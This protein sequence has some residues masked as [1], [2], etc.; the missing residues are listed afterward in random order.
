MTSELDARF[1]PPVVGAAT[2]VRFPVISRT[3]LPNGLR[4]WSLPWAP[5]PVAA[6][7]FILNHGAADDPADRPGLASLTADLVDEGAGTR[8]TVGLAAAF[9]SLGTHLEVEAGS[10]STALAFTVLTRFFE[11]ALDLVV[12]VLLRPRLAEVDLTRIRAQR[13]NRLRQ[14]KTSAGASA[15]RALLAGVFG[16]HPY[17]HGIMGTSAALEAASLD[18]VRTFHADRFAP[19]SATLIVAGDLDPARVADAVHARLGD[20]RA[21][22]PKFRRSYAAPAA[23]QPRVLLVDRPGAPQSEL[24]IGHLGPP[25]TTPAYHRLVT[26][27]AA[28]GGQFTSRVNQLLRETK[29]YTYSA[30]TSFD[31]RT[32]AGAFACD[33]SVE[34]DAT[35]AA[36]ADVL[37]ELAAVRS[38]R[39]IR[40]E[41]LARA[42]SSLTRGYVRHFETPEHLARAASEL[43]IF[44]LPDE[45]FDL[46]VDAVSALDESDLLEAARAFLDP[47]A[48]VIAV[49]GDRE[50]CRRGLGDLRGDVV[51][52]TPVF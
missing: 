1:R 34:T 17:G 13:I 38:D 2:P 26:L 5:L 48:C 19:A 39:P 9:S 46:F 12:D 29:G 22:A 45:T 35:A 41:E 37:G 27:N 10:E 11:Q 8:D 25:R 28:L 42:K 16:D 18:E 52:T 32:V 49:V 44:D 30:R 33:T 50:R 20:W 31:F 43:A 47:D 24:R 21:S 51:E 7:V 36:V 4:V 40:D 3:T 15:D 23:I 14:L 6:V